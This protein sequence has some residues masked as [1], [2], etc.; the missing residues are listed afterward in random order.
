MVQEQRMILNEEQILQKIKRI[1][2]EI[3]ENNMDEQELVLAGIYDRGY[4]VA[5]VLQRELAVIAPF[6]TTLVKVEIN[7]QA[8][9]ESSVSMD[10]EL[11]SLEQKSIILIDDVLN[12]G[13]TLTY[14]IKPF[15][16]IDLKKLQVAV[17]V[18]RSHKTF[19]VAA[20]FTGL[21]LSTTLENHIFVSFEEGNYAVYLH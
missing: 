2:Y 4:Y 6:K 10:T 13:K 1:A 18:N 17:L 15:L 14:S 12:T 16:N 11:A 5:Q 8:P 21:E 20:D 3:Y 9:L 7:K 19:P